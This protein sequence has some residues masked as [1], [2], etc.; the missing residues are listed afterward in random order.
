MEN[1]IE[2]FGTLSSVVVAISLMMRNIRRLRLLNLAGAA[3]F[4]L[5]G[6]AIGSIPVFALNLFI[7]LIDL[8][9]LLKM[10]RER[11]SFSLLHVDIERTEYLRSFLD[12]Y[13]RDIS[14]FAPEFKREELEGSRAVFVLRDMVPASLVIYRK[15]LDGAIELLLDYATPSWRD[16]KSAEYFFAAS[17]RDIAGW[18]K[19]LFRARAATKI[20]E[21]YLERMGFL[22]ASSGYW[23]LVVGE[24]ATA[25]G[26]QP[27]AAA[28]PAAS[29]DPA[30]P[31][32]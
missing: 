16:F 9:Y 6:L 30:A 5:Y 10:R 15:A 29:A 13:A 11:S 24:S 22:K 26:G 14:R 28:P 12:F 8:W 7:V 19:A 25:G 31:A 20:H 4:A 21:A 3:L 17:A 1:A 2:W 32:G 18:G 27:G 23:E